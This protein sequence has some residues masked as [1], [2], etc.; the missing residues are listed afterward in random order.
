MAEG[1]GAAISFNIGYVK[2]LPGILRVAQIVLAIIVLICVSAVGW[3]HRYGGDDFIYFTAA[4]ALIYSIIFTVL[5]LLNVPSLLARLPWVIIILIANV[6]FTLFYFI[7]FIIACVASSYYGGFNNTGSAHASFG[8]AAFF[9]L[10]AM[11]VHAFDAFLMFR[12]FRGGTRGG[13][14]AAH[15]PPSQP[16]PS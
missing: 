13:S 5:F 10:I 8:A 4:T 15:M 2:S 3:G 16:T 7:S 11:V 9:T 14:G 1:G 12:D 6:I